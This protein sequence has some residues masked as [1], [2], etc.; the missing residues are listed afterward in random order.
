MKTLKTCK[1]RSKHFICYIKM[2]WLRCTLSESHRH[3][4]RLI[5]TKVL[6]L[7][8]FFWK[9][10]F[11]SFA[12]KSEFGLLDEWL[13][14]LLLHQPNVQKGAETEYLW[15]PRSRQHSPCL[16][17]G[18]RH[19]GHSSLVSLGCLLWLPALTALVMDDCTAPVCVIGS[20]AL[21]F[22]DHVWCILKYNHS[23]ICCKFKYC[24][25]CCSNQYRDF[26]TL[27]LGNAWLPQSES[28]RNCQGWF[29]L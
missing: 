23:G 27:C 18:S 1:V 26:L 17:G 21:R 13:D 16:L 12:L 29:C 8:L 2:Q 15:S 7:L 4:L 24:D 22:W 14:G 20:F 5:R 6:G 11:Y 9:L 28:H 3:F 19:L 25:C 10:A